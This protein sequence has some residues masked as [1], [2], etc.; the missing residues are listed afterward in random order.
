LHIYFR[1]VFNHF[2]KDHPLSPLDNVFHSH[3]P[4][5]ARFETLPVQITATAQK[6]K[7]APSG[8]PH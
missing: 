6:T 4:R 5:P 7:G 1:F 3:F 2:R 8:A